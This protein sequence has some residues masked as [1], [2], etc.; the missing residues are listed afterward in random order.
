MPIVRA[1]ADLPAAPGLAQRLWTDLSR[2]PT[3][4]DG[5]SQVLEVSD[6]WPEAGAKLVW[7]STPA[8]RGRVTERVVE[9]E[10][11]LFATDIFEDQLNG[12]QTLWFE[13]GVVTME[14]D[15]SLP[16]SGPFRVLTDVL[17]IRRALTMALERT[18]RRFSTEVADEATL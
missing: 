12:R 10:E 6:S 9:H 18:L 7:R 17:F 13:P 3:F 4:I 11:G 16:G 1:S 15:Y 5:F 14:L 2:W 8:G